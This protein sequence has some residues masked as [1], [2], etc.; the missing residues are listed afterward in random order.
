M[1]PHRNL[2]L[3]FL[4][5]ALVS[6]SCT[7]S[8]VMDLPDDL[9]LGADGKGDHRSR[10]ERLSGCEKQE[11]LWQKRILPTEYDGYPSLAGITGWSTLLG[12]ANGFFSLR[13]SFTHVSDEMPRYRAKFIHPLGTVAK[14]EYQSE[15]G[16][17]YPGLL[18]EPYVCGLARASLAADPAVIGYTPGLAVKLFIDGVPSANIHVMSSLN[19]QGKNH[20]YFEHYFTNILPEPTGLLLQSLRAWFS[21]ATRVPTR[22]RVHHLV[23]YNADG[24]KTNSGRAPYQLYF[25]PAMGRHIDPDTKRD[26]RQEL[27]EIPPGSPLYDVYARASDK[28]RW[29]YLIGRVVTQSRFV[30]SRWGDT[31]LFFKHQE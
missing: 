10:Y 20:N 31:G 7:E 2:P 26:M 5:T 30:A 4:L 17:P 11:Y 13:K 1:N 21:T 23:H 28:D 22:L 19:G 8:T 12:N 27:A 24:S 15:P 3:T 9:D 6:I 18:S 25:Y 14:I 29:A 16:S